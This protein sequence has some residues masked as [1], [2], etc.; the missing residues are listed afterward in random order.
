MSVV[1]AR[2]VARLM[3]S[4]TSPGTVFDR[5]HSTFIAFILIRCRMHVAIVIASRDNVIITCLPCRNWCV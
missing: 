1:L 5:M 2:A 3:A 4:Y